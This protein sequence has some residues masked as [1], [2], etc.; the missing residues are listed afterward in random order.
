MSMASPQKFRYTAYR[1]DQ[2]CWIA[3][4]KSNGKHDGFYKSGFASSAEA[5]KAA[6]SFLSVKTSKLAPKPVASPDTGVIRYHGVVRK[7]YSYKEQSKVQFAC[8]GKGVKMRI[9][10]TQLEAAKVTGARLK[11]KF[12]KITPLTLLGRF[13]KWHPHF[14][15]RLPGDLDKVER[16]IRKD[17]AMFKKE[18]AMLIY[19]LQGKDGPFKRA[20]RDS[21]QKHVFEKNTL[22]P[23]H[24]DYRGRAKLNFS[25]LADAF[26]AM[27]NVDLDEWSREV[28]L[29]VKHVIGWMTMAR[30]RGM[31]KK[32]KKLSRHTIRI[33]LGNKLKYR[34]VVG[35]EKAKALR[36]LENDARGSDV[37]ASILDNPPD[38]LDAWSK[39]VRTAVDKLRKLPRMRLL[40]PG[41]KRRV[42]YSTIWTLRGAGITS[43]RI[44]GCKRLAAKGSML[45]LKRAFPDQGACVQRLAQALGVSNVSDFCKKLG[46]QCPIELL[47]MYLCFYSSPSLDAYDFVEMTPAR[48]RKFKEFLDGARSRM[49]MD[50]IPPVAIPTFC[51]QL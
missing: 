26:R 37:F 51:S 9:F 17:K 32:T 25:I 31:L 45:Q 23:K 4:V 49:G 33:G 29:R 34:L 40:N 21:F 42:P 35:K 36:I 8:F 44:A 18:P 27:D 1:E 43:M 47:H 28:N 13:R 10:K 2:K 19:S 38:T 22:V 16:R 12:D 11:S 41:S 15:G 48:K 20:L 5:A 7:T 30:Q 3:Q 39:M 50:S 24:D 14:R 6:A 46:Y